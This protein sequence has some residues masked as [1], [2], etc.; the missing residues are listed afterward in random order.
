[1]TFYRVLFRGA[2]SNGEEWQTG[3]GVDDVGLS[4]TAD[5][6]DDAAAAFAAEPL[7]LTRL[8]RDND[9]VSSLVVYRLPSLGGPATEVEE[10]I[11]GVPGTSSGLNALPNQVAVVASLRMGY[12]GRSRRGRM[13]LPCRSSAALNADGFLNDTV[14]P[15][16]AQDVADLFG[17]FNNALS[18][19]RVAVLS[20]TTGSAFP[21]T[22]VDV[23]NVC[24]TQ[25]RRRNALSEVRSTVSVPSV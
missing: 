25:R 13:F 23:G 2:F 1:M 7:A 22:S 6:A 18:G 4:S 12:P 15:L 8:L 9:S 17:N 24:D 16:V 21:V 3:F 5:V 11:L 20:P 10:R 19:R 14:R